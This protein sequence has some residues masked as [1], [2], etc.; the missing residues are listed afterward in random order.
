[1]N[2]SASSRN[3]IAGRTPPIPGQDSVA[4]VRYL[5]IGGVNQWLMIRG[6]D[7]A[8]PL[9]IMLHGGPGI[10]ETVFWRYYNSQELEKAFTVVYWDQ[11][12]SGKSYDPTL[13]KDTMTLEQFLSDL[14]EVVDYVC[15]RANKTKVT[16]FGHSWGSILGPL[17]AAR[18][19]Q[20][21]AAYIGSGQIGD[22]AAS[23]RA[24]Y[25]YT[26]SEAQRRSW[27]RIELDLKNVVGRP[28]HN[29]E[30]LIKQRNH[31]AKLDGDTSFG[32]VLMI[33]RIFLTAPEHSI[34]DLLQFY[35]ILAYNIELMWTEVTSVNL[36]E[37]VPELQ[38]PTFFLL[39]RNDHCVLPEISMEYIQV[40]KAPSKEV[41]WF[42]HSRHQPFMD[43]PEKFNSTMVNF[44]RPKIE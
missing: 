4:E 36:L 15:D 23:E 38:V 24:T 1:M 28:P 30:S 34:F 12:G 31:L 16:L 22:W 26:L 25:E 40:L 32:H 14:N 33:C 42:D 2:E 35:K 43:E 17:F 13:N 27:K 8:N 10:S 19:P 20:K 44:I 7:R 21:V 11:R 3:W 39:G 18:Y 41:V 29:S 5:C 9:L 37:S 6:C